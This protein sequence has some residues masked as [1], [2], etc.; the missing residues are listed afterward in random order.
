MIIPF[1]MEPINASLGHAW[2]Y[3]VL[4]FICL[5]CDLIAVIFVRPRVPVPRQRKKLSD[6][7][8]LNVLKDTNFLLFCIG[9]LVTLLGYFVPYFFLPGYAKEI[10]L[11]PAQGAALV[12][13]SSAMNFVGRI[14]AGYVGQTKKN[15]G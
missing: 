4:G 7:I 8:Q 2:T 6:I 1:V 12:A 11:D 3:R 5:G 13:T 9:S 15:R 14:L 10:N